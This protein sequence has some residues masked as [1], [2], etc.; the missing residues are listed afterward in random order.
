MSV[1]LPFPFHIDPS[2]P[3]MTNSCNLPGSRNVSIGAALLLGV[4]MFPVQAQNSLTQ[5]QFAVNDAGAAT[6]SIPISVAPGVGGLSP[7]LSLQY[8][9]QAPNGVFGVGWTLSG[10]SSITRCAKTPAEDGDRV[11][12]QNNAADLFCLDGQKLRVVNGKLNGADGAQY[13]TAV[14]TYGRITSLGNVAG[15]PQYFTLETKTGEIYT[16]G[17]NSESRLEHPSKGVI[18]TWMVSEIKDRFSN[19]IGFVYTK[20]VALG[21]QLLSRVDYSNGRVQL[22]YEPRPANDQILKYDDGVQFGSTNSRVGT[23]TVAHS[24]AAGGSTTLATFKS[25][26]LQ[27]TQSQASQRSMIRSIQEC[28]P[29]GNC[30]PATTLA[31]G[32]GAPGAFRDA[33]AAPVIS[34]PNGLRDLLGD[35]KQSI[36]NF[37]TNYYEDVALWDVDG[38]GRTDLL[39]KDL[40]NNDRSP[41][42]RE[43]IQY[44]NG[45]Q[46]SR[47]WDYQNHIR[48]FADINGD[49][50]SESISFLARY[51]GGSNSG[52]TYYSVSESSGGS[53][54]SLGTDQ[55]TSCR[56]IDMDGDG[57]SEVFVRMYSSATHI[58]LTHKQGGFSRVPYVPELG[59]GSVNFGDF[60]GDGKTDWLSGGFL[61]SARTAYISMGVGVGPIAGWATDTGGVSC[62]G[63]FN[64]DGRTDVLGSQGVLHIS[65]GKVLTKFPYNS[66][67]AS[68]CGDFNGDGL[69]D[70]VSG[71]RYWYNDLPIAVDRLISVDNGAGL[72]QEVSYKPITDNSIYT[73][74]T[75][76][77]YPQTDMQTPIIVVSQVK[78]SSGAGAV[79]QL[80]QTTTYRYAALR[81]DLKR[82]GTQGFE[83]VISTNVD[84]GISVATHYNQQ[85]PLTGLRARVHKYLGSDAAPQ[86]LENTTYA[87]KQL[88]LEALP[89]SQAAQVYLEKST[90][91]FYD[92]KTP[93]VLLRSV[94]EN[95]AEVDKYGYPLLHTVQQ[96]DGAGVQT[97]SSTTRNTYN[98]IVVGNWLLGQLTSTQTQQQNNR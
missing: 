17:G 66:R 89:S 38:D 1:A 93:G 4:L 30:L 58:H 42:T 61:L 94:N 34:T 78:S 13:R 32:D 50:K 53:S 87:Y 63:D 81:A 14:D 5:G 67:A 28:V 74:G 47:V 41:P 22:A 40:Q 31:Y 19:R 10:V 43:I 64:G 54:I 45:T 98:H 82:S 15:G 80:W 72:V 7:K 16:F 24:P 83:R 2:C 51:V 12:V 25:Y 48:C 18:R 77:S 71:G 75:G 49:G 9:S 36:Y 56:S 6:Y 84:T 59:S 90:T 65:N 44:A 37:R 39:T 60:N 79:P 76:A 35:G 46:T 52:S 11:G 62:T 3:V 55:P 26:Q 70:Y 95:W 33:G 96:L 23:I 29:S 27:Y 8:S 20:N 91:A 97:S 88:P 92:L 68:I 86:T 69:M 73:K 85:F 57:R 21:E